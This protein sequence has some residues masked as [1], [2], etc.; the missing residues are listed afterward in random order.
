[1][2]LKLSQR[3]ELLQ[4]SDELAAEDLTQ[5]L[6]GQKEAWRG[7]DPSGT[8]GSK[9]TSGND[10]VNMGMMLKVLSPGMEDADEAYVGSKVLG[11]AGQF[12]HRCGAGAVEQVIEQPLVLEDKGGQF[13]RQSEDDME[14]RHGQQFSRAR[15]QP[16]CACVPLALWAVP[17]ATRV[18]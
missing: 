5:C 18:E 8:V 16:F 11:I 9:A 6:N 2:K 3:E 15:R 1:M 13:V 7:I 4:S 17:I 10:V 12:E 14:V